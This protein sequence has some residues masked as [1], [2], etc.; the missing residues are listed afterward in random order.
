MYSLDKNLTEYL[1]T[2]NNFKLEDIPYENEYGYGSSRKVKEFVAQFSENNKSESSQ[3]IIDIARSLFQ[4]YGLDDIKTD[5]GYIFYISYQYNDEN[6]NYNYNNTPSCENEDY[7]NVHS[8]Y[9]I[10][11]KDKQLEKGN[12]DIYEDYN[13]STIIG[14]DDEKKTEIPLQTGSAF[15][16]DGDTLFNIQTCYGQG[17]INLIRVVFLQDDEDE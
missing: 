5:R 12:L 11:Q 9:I 16:I 3:K 7:S 4:K 15:I 1:N 13:I 10:T 6:Y 2:V 14:L 8:C 17:N